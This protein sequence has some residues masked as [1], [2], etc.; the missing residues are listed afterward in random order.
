[1]PLGSR[2]GPLR[3]ILGGLWTPKNT[4]H[5]LLLSLST[6]TAAAHSAAFAVV[7]TVTPIAAAKEVSIYLFRTSFCYAL[8]CILCSEIP[9]LF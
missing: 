8:L 5:A 6:A 4:S 7:T 3:A 2:L 9:T 1:M